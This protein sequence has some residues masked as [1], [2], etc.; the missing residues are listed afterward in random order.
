[1]RDPS[2]NYVLIGNVKIYLVS[3]KETLIK[4]TYCLNYDEPTAT[5]KLTTDGGRVIFEFSNVPYESAAK[6]AEG[7]GLR[8]WQE[9]AKSTSWIRPVPK[10]YL[11]HDSSKDAEDLK[12]LALS[13]NIP[14]RVSQSTELRIS[15]NGYVYTSPMWSMEQMRKIILDTAERDKDVLMTKP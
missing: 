4:E 9:L 8:L 10:I 3:L 14:L 13:F 6:L 7:L 15:T 1:M 5:V 12:Q 2:S 11:D